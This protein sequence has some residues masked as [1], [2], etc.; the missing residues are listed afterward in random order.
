MQNNELKSNLF[1]EF[2]LVR[3]SAHR[4]LVTIHRQLINA[5]RIAE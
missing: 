1:E 2:C 4:Q 5:C 3:F